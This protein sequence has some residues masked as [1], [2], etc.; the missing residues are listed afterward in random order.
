MAQ[1][2]IDYGAYPDDG[3]ANSI[4]DAFIATQ[5]NFTELFNIPQA[6]VSQLVGGAGI[7]LTNPSG[8]IA[9]Q[10][11]GNVNVSA[12]I[13]KITFQA[14]DPSNPSSLGAQLL[15]FNGNTMATINASNPGSIPDVILDINS[16][17]LANFNVANLTVSNRATIGNSSSL[18]SNLNPPL[19]VIGANTV[20]SIPSGNIVADHFKTTPTGR[21]V[22]NVSLRDTPYSNVGGIVY[23]ALSPVPYLASQGIQVL[24][25]D[26]DFL[27]Y[28]A[29]NF[30][31]LT[32]NLVANNI[33]AN[34]N[35]SGTFVGNITGNITV[36]GI[37]RGLVIK[38]NAGATTANANSGALTYAA[39]GL[40]SILNTPTDFTNAAITVANS[41]QIIITSTA[42]NFQVLNTTS[43]FDSTTGAIVVTGGVG[44][45]GS[46]NVGTGIFGNSLGIG[47]S[48]GNGGLASFTVASNGEMATSSNSAVLIGFES[49]TGSFRTVGGISVGN[50]LYVGSANNSSNTNTGAVRI[51]GG[52]GI[53]ANLYVGDMLGVAQVTIGAN[54]PNGGSPCVAVST[55]GVITI[56]NNFSGNINTSN[57][58]IRTDGG[59][60][61]NGNVRISAIDQ[62]NST[63]TGSFITAGGAGIGGNLYV[64]G[65]TVYT[66]ITGTFAINS[67]QGS[68]NS[69]NGAFTVAG[70]AGIGERLHVGSSVAAN[71]LYIGN[72]AG[73]N[74]FAN[75][76]VSISPTGVIETTS[77]STSLFPNNASTL[78]FALGSSS[79][80][81][82]ATT[83]NTQIRTPN[84]IGYPLNS[85][86]SLFD[87][88]TTSTMNF[89]GNSS[90][91][92]IGANSGT[93]TLQNP[94]IVGT[95]STQNVFNT[96]TTF[97]NAFGAA[98]LINMGA[99]NA[100]M[101]LSASN[102][103]GSAGQTTQLLFDSVATTVNAFGAASSINMGAANSTLMLRSNT[104][105]GDSGQTSLSLFNTIANTVNA[106]GQANTL[107]IG[108][109]N[110]TL[111]LRSNTVVGAAGQTTQNLYDTVT[112][113]MNFA[114]NATSINLGASVDPNVTIGN[115]GGTGVVLIRGT[116]NATN[117]SYLS[118]ALQVAGGGGFAKDV[119]IGG[120]LYLVGNSSNGTISNTIITIT[121][122]SD[123]ANSVD[124]SASFSTAGGVSIAKSLNVGSNVRANYLG[125]GSNA[126][127]V[128]SGESIALFGDS[129]QS[130]IETTAATFNIV[131]D[132]AGIVNLGGQATTLNIG[133]NSAGSKML[134]RNPAVYGANTL[135][136]LYDNVATTMFFARSA[137]TLT[138][139]ATSGT[140]TIQNPTLIGTQTTQNLYN[141]T[142]V[143]LNIGGESTSI[144]LGNVSGTMTL[145]NP[146][147]VGSQI[148]QNLFNTVATTI[149][150]GNAA[151]AINVGAN[152]GTVTI[153]NPTVV[154]TE[155]G[156]NLWNTTSTTVNAFGAATTIE[157]GAAT[158]NTNIN[159]NLDVDG[160][161]NIDG[162]SLTVSTANFNIANT[163][164]TTIYFGGQAT[165]VFIGASTGN[166][167]VNNNLVLGADLDVV[168]GD[169]TTNQTSF[170]VI[171]TNATTVN[172]FGAATTLVLG[173]TSGTANIRNATV[174]MP[175]NLNVTQLA[176]FSANANVTGNLNVTANANVTANVNAG[177]VN[178]N[179][180]LGGA[181]ATLYGTTLTTGGSGTAGTITG[182][183]SLSGGSKLNATYADLAEYY[184]S[185]DEYPSGTVLLFDGDKEVTLS[186][187]YDSTKVAGVVS[188]N[189]AYVMNA[190][191][192][193][194]HTVMLALQ[195]RVPTKVRG[196]V[197]KGDLMVS[198]PNGFAAANN[199]ARAGTI[200]GKALQNFDGDKGVIEIVIGKM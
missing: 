136:Q 168:G 173:S 14:G 161:V 129:T 97:V 147:I 1:R 123:S 109:A 139:G 124:T 162:G 165:N 83:G 174:N 148:T 4:R 30:S 49:S 118:G 93:L 65:N 195:G 12:N 163:T 107:N 102:V 134:I 33:T 77:N 7:T 128:G 150:F 61:A 47:N 58:S 100:T 78:N 132:T 22:G 192:E 181:S 36:S 99:S 131:N 197:K 3:N 130:N 151:T 54:A 50:N 160:N 179:G 45:G 73:G 10:L 34:G 193:A 48:A 137:S 79:L 44:I 182:N 69:A 170:N 145:R 146:I 157:I 105:V 159:H 166:T 90:T 64:G 104:I 121:N 85:T 86:Q 76:V 55:T 190:T 2:N 80:T 60:L 198:A 87:S 117:N 155:T 23:N 108:A 57:Y 37:D 180:Q 35:I 96:V 114:G 189:P 5:E 122:T 106:F 43:S 156:I 113:T 153:S 133:Q 188:T 68:A 27:R 152:T 40:F 31:L 140:A 29:A 196:P 59:I 143:T 199:Q 92:R 120:N 101:I 91:I 135:Q 110:S 194:P 149:N 94:T 175:G 71:S 84:I 119:F 67:I 184:E 178:S 63:T 52:V 9:T 51:A 169:I 103:V 20:N 42:N 172:A 75:A 17:F 126:G 177:N 112:A 19:V 26:P 167:T 185:D 144:N 125:V 21:V 11:S 72:N 74:G 164:A 16:N 200:I 186:Y 62:A 32:P 81:I 142:A 82:G 6:G 176:T 127:G 41:S 66:S 115:G 111:T 24:T 28:D 171:N 25:T 18:Y 13:Y 158:G 88:A 191:L 46:L 138:M 187:E 70:G 38:S 56:T 116:Q 8:T 39:N 15:T 53:G 183:W 154:G 141:T 95:S 98:S 89:A